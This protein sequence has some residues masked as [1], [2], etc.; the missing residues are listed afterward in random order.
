M[1]VYPEIRSS[2]NVRVRATTSR[3]RGGYDDAV[4]ECLLG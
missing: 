2:P 3:P 4:D 1:T